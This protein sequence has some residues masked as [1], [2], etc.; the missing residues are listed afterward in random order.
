MF[1]LSIFSFCFS[2]LSL[3][4]LEKYQDLIRCLKMTDVQKLCQ[5]Q[6]ACT[7]DL[8]MEMEV[9][10]WPTLCFQTPISITWLE[11]PSSR[12]HFPLY[13]FSSFVFPTL[14][15]LFLRLWF[16]DIYIVFS[17]GIL[18]IFPKAR[19]IS[20]PVISG[21]GTQDHFSEHWRRKDKKAIE[22]MLLLT[23]TLPQNS[24]NHTILW[25]KP[26]RKYWILSSPL[27]N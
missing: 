23:T 10:M 17:I 27:S 15:G 2:E 4:D 13:L 1:G 3:K 12:P 24:N 18:V 6:E 11:Q 26:D 5:M 25:L 7:R 22:T 21:K 19:M 14:D 8:R 16:S 20:W 9:F